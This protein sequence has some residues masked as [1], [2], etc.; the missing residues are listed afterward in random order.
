MTE[1]IHDETYNSVPMLRNK[2][3]QNALDFLKHVTIIDGKIRAQRH[4][5]GV[6]ARDKI[7]SEKDFGR[8]F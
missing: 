6:K 4:H 1:K 5:K 3:K 2:G 8:L 7:G